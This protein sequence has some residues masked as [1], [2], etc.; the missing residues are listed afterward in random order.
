MPTRTKGKFLLCN[1]HNNNKNYKIAIQCQQ[2]ILFMQI[3]KTDKSKRKQYDGQ[4]STQNIKTI[5]SKEIFE[6]IKSITSKKFKKM[7]YIID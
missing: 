6:H 2:K 7:F 4:H 3:K 5:Y 1:K